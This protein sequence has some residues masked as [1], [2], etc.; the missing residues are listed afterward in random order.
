M[1]RPR[2]KIISFLGYLTIADGLIN[3][4]LFLML[5]LILG[6][7]SSIYSSAN[8]LLN[9]MIICLYILFPFVFGIGLLKGTKWSWYGEIILSFYFIFICLFNFM[10]N[11]GLAKV[12]RTSPVDLD[13]SI[14]ESILGILIGLF[15]Y[16]CLTRKS[17][18]AFFNIK[19]KIV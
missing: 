14:M 12:F 2:P 19:L 15:I 18:K 10:C 13:M 17:I 16:F 11:I 5:P 1:N 9:L 3:L 6:G 4:I 7:V 8:D